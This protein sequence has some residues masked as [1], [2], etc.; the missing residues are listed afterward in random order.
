MPDSEFMK[1][2]KAEQEVLAQI[3]HQKQ[4]CDNLRTEF[5]ALRSDFLESYDAIFRPLQSSLG[6]LM[7]DAW[8]GHR[9][10][11]TGS[12]SSCAAKADDMKTSQ[13]IGQL[14]SS[15]KSRIAETLSVTDSTVDQFEEMSASLRKLRALVTGE[16]SKDLLE[17]LQTKKQLLEKEEEKLKS[18]QDRYDHY[19]GDRA[20]K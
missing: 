16:D 17:E 10:R 3:A 8:D 9:N 1:L 6:R 5:Q 7:G 20:K 2:E 11:L 14:Q 4:T 15:L 13:E 12:V 19:F 18:L